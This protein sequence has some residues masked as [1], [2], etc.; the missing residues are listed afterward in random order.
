MII[1]ICIVMAYAIVN[2]NNR[3]IPIV[4]KKAINIINTNNNYNLIYYMI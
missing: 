2:P 3:V 4:T 1:K